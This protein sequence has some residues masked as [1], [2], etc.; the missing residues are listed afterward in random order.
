MNLE[1]GDLIQRNVFLGS[2][3]LPETNWVDSILRPG[4]AVV[5][6]GAN[7]GYY[8]SLF[9]RIVG[10]TGLVVAVEANP[11]LAIRLKEI[12]RENRLGNV[13]VIAAG[14]SDSIGEATLYIPP[15]SFGNND[16]TMTPVAGWRP[17][18]VRLVTL[19]RELAQ[20]DVV[21][22]R[23]LKVDVEGHELR[24]L[25]GMSK[26]LVKGA[27]DYLLIELNDHW[28]KQQGTSVVELVSFCEEMGFDTLVRGSF[29]KSDQTTDV[30][31]R[32][33]KVSKYNCE[34]RSGNES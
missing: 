23:L 9:R 15:S 24:V 8:T 16:A 19:D 21:K 11:S 25:K 30:L 33:S 27:V 20:L 12:V 10:S 3:E 32:H 1:L 4:D 18:A 29:P 13:A 34:R 2:Y 5:D 28:L 17:I 26:M 6:V 14:A 31:L 7:C 22:I